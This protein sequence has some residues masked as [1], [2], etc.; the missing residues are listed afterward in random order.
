LFGVIVQFSLH[1]VE[2]GHVGV[3]FRGGAMLQSMSGPGF[4][5]MVPFL[6]MVRNIQTTLQTDEVKNVPC[7]T[8]GG[9]MIY[10]DRIEVVNVLQQGAV[11]DIVKNYTADYDKA[12]IF[13]KV[14]HEL[15]QFCSGHTL[16]EVYIELFDQIDE[17]LKIALQA[18]LLEM[19]PGLKVHAVRVT[20]PKIP[21]AIRKNFELMEAE[22]TKLLISTQKQKVIEKDAETERKKAVIEA[23]K[24]AQVAKIRYEQNILEKESLQKMETINDEVH[25][26]KERSRADAEFYK[27]Q[28]LAEAN[29]LLLTK[30]Y[31]DLKKIEAMSVNN[32]VYFGPDI[33]NM[34]ISE[35]DAVKDTQRVVVTEEKSL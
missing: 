28:K 3:Y 21:E 12:L 22:K 14:H 10:F 9:V 7:G 23:E 27:I 19:A 17:N 26:A 11:Y 1:K 20:K 35:K 25:L 16:Q 33:P 34:F 5:M 30:E 29:R 4:H 8:S 6:T 24:E 18:D 13:N 31:L 15:N 2:E 32:K